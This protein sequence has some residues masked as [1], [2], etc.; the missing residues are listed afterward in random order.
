MVPASSELPDARPTSG[1]V[2]V[3]SRTFTARLVAPTPI[4]LQADSGFLQ[5]HRDLRVT[6]CDRAAGPVRFL[7]I[8]PSQRRW[9]RLSGTRF[10]LLALDDKD[11]LW[12]FAG[13]WSDRQ[14]HHAWSPRQR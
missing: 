4:T 3:M 5:G 13:Q 2:G 7:R 9:V 11:N 8:E 12:E 14:K 1:L 6:S 10:G